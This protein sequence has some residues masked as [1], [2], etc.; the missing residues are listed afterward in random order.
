MK[1]GGPHPTTSPEDQTNKA[2][3]VEGEGPVVKIVVEELRGKATEKAISCML[4]GE[5]FPTVG[6]AL[7]GIC[8]NVD[9]YPPGY[10]LRPF[11]DASVTF[12]RDPSDLQRS[13]RNRSLGFTWPFLP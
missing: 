11:W 8:K 12:S 7:E 1:N 2:F 3:A 6:R 5:T 4:S 10:S 13:W 9:F